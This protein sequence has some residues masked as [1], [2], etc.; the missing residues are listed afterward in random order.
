[1]ELYKDIDG[2]SGVAAFEIGEGWIKVQFL[3]GGT[4]LYDSAKPGQAH[5]EEMQRLARTGDG[6]NAYIN[7]FIRKNFAAKLS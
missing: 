4:Y 3:K 2:D 1:M 5:V 7:K 6:L